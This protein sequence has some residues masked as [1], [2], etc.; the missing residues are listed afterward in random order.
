MILWCKMKEERMVLEIIGDYLLEY[1]EDESG[2]KKENMYIEF[3][4]RN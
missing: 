3:K 1:R 2:I 4:R